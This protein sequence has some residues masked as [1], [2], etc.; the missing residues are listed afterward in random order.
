MKYLF[1]FRTLSLQGLTQYSGLAFPVVYSHLFYT[2]ILT[3]KFGKGYTL[4]SNET[5]KEGIEGLAW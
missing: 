1:S 5:T 3:P 4:I 2:F